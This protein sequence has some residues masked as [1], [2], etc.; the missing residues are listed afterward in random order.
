MSKFKITIFDADVGS[1][2]HEETF[3]GR[4]EAL[5][6]ARSVIDSYDY[7]KEFAVRLESISAGIQKLSFM[8]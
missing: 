8:K 1:N 5:A 3:S 4:H 6:S 7:E 2:V